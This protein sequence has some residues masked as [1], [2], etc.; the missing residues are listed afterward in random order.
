MRP[1]SNSSRRLTLVFLAVLVPA[2][3][4]L[5]WLGLRL[6]DQDRALWAQRDLERQEAAADG[7]VRSLGGV[8]TDVDRRLTEGSRIPDAVSLERNG[9]G[10]S[11]SPPGAVAWHASATALTE[12]RG[13]PFTAAESLEHRGEA[14]Q[15]LRLY[16][17]A[18]RASERGVRA[19]ALLRRARVLRNLDRVDDALSDY[20]ALALYSDLSLDGM[21]VELLARRAQCGLLQELSRRAELARE[22]ASLERDLLAARWTLNRIDWELAAGQIAEWTGRPLVASPLQIAHAD[23]ADWFRTANLSSAGR[24]SAAF[25]GLSMTLLWTSPGPHQRAVVLVPGSVEKWL[26]V[27][28]SQAGPGVLAL[29]ALDDRGEAIAGQA[30]PV[31]SRVVRRTA[32]E[33]GLPW[34]VVVSPGGAWATD[35]EF[36]SRRRLLAGGLASLGLL[37][38]GGAWFLWRLVQRE[39]AVARLQTAFVSAV[40]HEF[41][42][43]VTSLR[44]SIELLKENDDITGA[45]RQSFYD[46]MGRST[47]RLHRLVESLLDF[48]RM[49]EG[50]KAFDLRPLD[51]LKFTSAVATEFAVDVAARGHAIEVTSDG[52]PGEVMADP[53]A[54]GHALWNVLDN[55]AKYS[56]DGGSIFVSV[57]RQHAGVAIAVT[58]TGLGVPRGERQEIFG[59]FVRGSRA[60]Q[61][62]I[63]G[64]GVGL[65]IVAHVMKG[66]G[67]SV[68]LESEVGKGSTFRLHLPVAT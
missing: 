56:P 38:S 23:A 58:D 3:V 2:A 10:V 29:A 28:A 65:A 51:V 9:G 21:P 7:I 36:K 60:H 14:H 12:L 67:G 46:V 61:L 47:E 11:V 52:A 37:L 4:T 34:T 54:L 45:R 19:G 27:A 24:K 26:A 16:D 18:T 25:Q 50:R 57:E 66:H 5:V 31:A 43:P 55:A 17:A 30:P 44:H 32:L 39:L 49:E 62:G 13:E 41:R 33:T 68:E 22:A 8:L 15:A 64:T 1:P 35:V 53:D 63:K 6:L 20:R 42:T 59:K 40:S 48:G